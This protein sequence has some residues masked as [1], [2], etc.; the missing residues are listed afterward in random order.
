L[1][2]KTRLILVGSLSHPVAESVSG[3]RDLF[4]IVEV[5]DVGKAQDLLGQGGYAAVL[6]A[7]PTRPEG[8]P[9]GGPGWDARLLEDLPDGVALVNGDGKLVWVN[10]RFRQLC[11]RDDVIGEGFYEAFGSPLILG[12]DFSPFAT[13]LATGEPATAKLQVGDKD[14][15]ELHVAP[16]RGLPGGDGGLVVVVRHITPEM[17]QQQK[18]EAI[19]QAGIELTDLSP[20]E[21]CAMT[22]EERVELLKSNI[23]HH[24]QA[25]LDFNVVEI[26]LLDPTTGR[27]NPLLA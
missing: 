20:E 19:H 18:L 23:L 17:H 4:E 25:I 15:W 27:L 5:P 10:G 21:S 7:G 24:T 8:L 16:I 12:P 2:A 13:A 22:V 1:S 14:F 6:C 26:R 9:R 3:L 11:G